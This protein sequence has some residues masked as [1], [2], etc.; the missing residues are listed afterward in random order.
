LALGKKNVVLLAST[1]KIPP[2][3]PFLTLSSKYGWDVALEEV[4]F[5]SHHARPTAFEILLS[6]ANAFYYSVKKLLPFILLI[7]VPDFKKIYIYI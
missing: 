5:H 6:V 1:E 4:A 2:K 7:S 3:S